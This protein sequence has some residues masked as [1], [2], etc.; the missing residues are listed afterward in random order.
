MGMIAIAVTVAAVGAALAWVLIHLGKAPLGYEDEAGF[1]VVQHVKA[2]GIQ[3]HR[4]HKG[5]IAGTLR[6]ARAHS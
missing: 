2:S 5:T 4:K 3:R 6:G 1:H